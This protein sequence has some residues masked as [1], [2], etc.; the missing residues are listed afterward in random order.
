MKTEAELL[1]KEM[2]A[3]VERMRRAGINVTT[4]KKPTDAITSIGNEN[5]RF[6][7]LITL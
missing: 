1:R 4:I 3:F 2:A 5:C 7:W 6:D